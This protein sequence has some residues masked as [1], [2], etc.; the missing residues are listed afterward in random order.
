MVATNNSP[1]R[2]THRGTEAASIRIGFSVPMCLGVSYLLLML[3]A[4][5]PADAGSADVADAA[6]RQDLSAVRALVGKHADVN[7]AQADGTTA[8]HWA[9]HWNDVDA[10]KLLLRAG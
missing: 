6:Q 8:L 9:V 3:F 7:A 1:R 2:T 5:T 10:A 4:A